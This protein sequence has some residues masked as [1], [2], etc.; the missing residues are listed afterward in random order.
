MAL[1]GFMLAMLGT[2]AGALVALHLLATV[3]PTIIVAVVAAALFML[4]MIALLM[5]ALLA[6][7]VLPVA[8]L[9]VAVL[10]MIFAL[11]R[12]M[13]G[14]ALGL[15]GRSLGCRRRRNKKRD[16]HGDGLHVHFL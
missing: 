14:V 6:L 10:T 16:R 13:I 2:T 15:S 11:R 8:V 12:V 1:M 3:H 9:P 5:L 7:A 4:A